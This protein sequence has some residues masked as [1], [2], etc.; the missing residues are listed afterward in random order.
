MKTIVRTRIVS[1]VVLTALLLAGCSGD[2]FKLAFPRIEVVI[3]KDGNPTIAGVSPLILR[4]VGVD[5]SGVKLD[6]TMVQQMTD[7]NIQHVELLFHKSGLFWWINAQ[8]MTPLAWDDESFNNT[9]DLVV[10]LGL[11]DPAQVGMVKALVPQARNLEADVLIRFPLQA[12]ATPIEPR[13]LGTPLP[14]P[15]K[16]AGQS[17]VAGLKLTFD[18]DG[19]PSLAGVSTKDIGKATGMDLSTVAIPPDTMAQLAKA[20]IQHITI[21]TTP[22]GLRIWTNDKPLPVVRWSEETL[23]STAEVLG[24][25]KMVD[26]A[27]A[28]MLKQFVP[29]VNT[30]DVNIVL[31][32]P[33]N[34]AAEIPLP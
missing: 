17:V 7:S 24:G 23:K 19:T 31:R 25:M 3:D 15:G 21:R 10:N 2:S 13:S 29:F 32:F 9:L 34:G 8:P 28:S 12:G 5:L 26:P 14:E 22:E 1:V 16:P 6:P 11:I 20:G 30:L 27:L 33:A 4:L 18:A